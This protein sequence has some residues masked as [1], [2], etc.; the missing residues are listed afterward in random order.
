MTQ[1]VDNQ[2][3][4]EMTPTPL[5]SVIIPAYNHDCWIVATLESVLSQS[6]TDF[7]LIVVDDGSKD[8]T[9]EIV[10]TFADER[11][12][13]VR[14]ENRG[15]AAAINRGLSLSRGRYIAILNSD[16]FF[17][18][19]RLETL[20][21]LLESRPETMLACSRVSL[22]DADG[23]ALAK[24]APEC[25]WLKEAEADFHKSGDLLLSLLRDNFICTSSNFFFRRR[26]IFEIGHFRD[27]RYVNDLD[28]LVRSLICCPG[29]F[30]QQDL[31]AYRQHSDNTLGERKLD[32]E[33]DFLLEVAWVLAAAV[34]TE[35]LGRQWDFQVFCE[36]LAKYYRLNLE[37]LLFSILC[38]RLQDKGFCTPGE[39]GQEQFAALLE[40]SSRRLNE[41]SF[42]E[43][44]TFQVEEQLSH[45][46]T[47][48]KAKKFH[49]EQSVAWQSQSELLQKQNQDFLCK[50]RERDQELAQAEQLQ[51][52]IW[53]NREWYR[54]Q[55]ET[56]VNSKRFRLFTLL[57]KVRRGHDRSSNLRELLRL[58]LPNTWRVRLRVWRK[59]LQSLRDPATLKSV[60][61]ERLKVCYQRLFARHQF[62][63]TVWGEA[64]APLLS[65]LVL[66]DKDAVQ[67]K[68]FCD[69]LKQQTWS[70]FEVY[71]LLFASDQKRTELLLARLGKEKIASWHT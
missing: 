27:L 7:E 32:K 2:E 3:L 41:Q 66:C 36:L 35:G 71:F 23:I 38:F 9:A 22:V 15:T 28:F 48:L 64:T 63:Q 61:N 19:K 17:K 21:D 4:A 69:Q 45:I 18:P 37:T 50:M 6:L 1:R 16:D 26:L 57:G 12:K 56:V 33:A 40:S 14:Q 42:V 55:Y 10:S 54:Q 59:R 47:L 25:V 11:L 52:E 31:L 29:V 67:V 51:H 49:L 60:F 53:Q 65:L 70:E 5:V 62:E 68:L 24:E 39:L 44:L 8:R 30:C 58:L 46:Q 13:L 43:G 20:V 34:E